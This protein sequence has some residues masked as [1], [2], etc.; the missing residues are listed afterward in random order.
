MENKERLLGLVREQ[1]YADLQHTDKLSS[2]YTAIKDAHAKEDWAECVKVWKEV[3]SASEAYG[4]SKLRSM[5]ELQALHRS[6]SW[7]ELSG[8]DF[9][10][11]SELWGGV[12]LVIEQHAQITNEAMKHLPPEKSK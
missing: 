10:A 5:S 2:L 1:L 8:E 4:E 7:T 11:L 6:I 3:E 12:R 9:K